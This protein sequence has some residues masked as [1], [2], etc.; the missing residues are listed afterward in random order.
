MA[1]A[2][3]VY[4]PHAMVLFMS[5]DGAGAKEKDNE[6]IAVFSLHNSFTWKLQG[7][8]SLSI[9]LIQKK[10]REKNSCKGIHSLKKQ[11][12]KNKIQNRTLASDDPSS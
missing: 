2:V 11:K 9:I 6:D 10:K 1:K 8:T 5:D 4:N 7:H 3:L 12:T